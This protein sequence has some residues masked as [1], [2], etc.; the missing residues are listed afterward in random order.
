MNRKEQIE[1]LENEIAQKQQTLNELR[2]T[3]DTQEQDDIDITQ[4][5]IDDFISN[6]FN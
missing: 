2:E 6:V 3:E 1:N 5:D 4:G